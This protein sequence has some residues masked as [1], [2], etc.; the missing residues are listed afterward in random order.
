[1]TPRLNG[2]QQRLKRA[3]MEAEERIRAD[4]LAPQ[5]QDQPHAHE[6]GD[7]H[8][9]VGCALKRDFIAPMEPE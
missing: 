6:K 2:P 9:C 3:L 8:L 7:E 1:M 4:L 5:P